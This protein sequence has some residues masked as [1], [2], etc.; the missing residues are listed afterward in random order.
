MSHL[1]D[2]VKAW[3]EGLYKAGPKSPEVR[4]FMKDPSNYELDSASINRSKGA[5]FNETY[6]D[7]ET[8]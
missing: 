5:K 8:K 2:A 7:P 1:K 6:R 3:N 4:Q